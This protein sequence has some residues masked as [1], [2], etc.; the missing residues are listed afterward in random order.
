MEP[1][2]SNTVREEEKEEED[3]FEKSQCS[4]NIEGLHASYITRALG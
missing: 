3:S 4:L 2:S 1:H